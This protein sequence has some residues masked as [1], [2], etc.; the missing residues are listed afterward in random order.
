MVTLNT[1]MLET[2]QI[3][4]G[5]FELPSLDSNPIRVLRDVSAG[6]Q[7]LTNASGGGEARFLEWLHGLSRW[8]VDMWRRLCQVS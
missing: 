5:A 7:Q 1:Y 8:P 4:N 3:L 6:R 2:Y